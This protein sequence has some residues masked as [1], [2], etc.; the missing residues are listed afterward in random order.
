MFFFR[1]YDI[2]NMVND[3]QRSINKIIWG[4]FVILIIFFLG[5][6]I[7]TEYHKRNSLKQFNKKIFYMD[8][9]IYI[10][11][12]TKDEKTANNMLKEAEK[13]YQHY[14]QIANR[15]EEFDNIHNL[16]YIK[17]NTSKEDYITIDKDLYEMLKIGKKWYQKSNR[18]IDISLGN[19]IDVW[20][21]Y[22]NQETGVP[23][24]K[25]LKEAH[26]DSIDDI[27]LKDNN[28][29]KNNHVNIDL[30]AI[31]KGYATDKVA[32]YFKENNMN[33]Y[34]INAGGN[35]LVG[36]HYDNG[37]YKI[38]IEDPTHSNGAIYTK[39]Q[40]NN[41]AV[42]TSGGYER[43]YEYKGKKY[44]HVINPNTLFPSDDKMSVTVIGNNSTEADILSTM[45]F[46]MDIEE[47]KK[48]VDTSDNLEAIWYINEKEQIESNGFKEYY[49]E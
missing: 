20:K 48:Y 12:Y 34:L 40:A 17:N 44:H 5:Y 29:I 26:T 16:Y 41:K 1:S 3:M 7:F 47:G 25:E 9:Y 21:K 6:I 19:V 23:S 49:F 28:R 36:E 14:H 10:N 46:L 39:V 42:V 38:G 11:L 4:I 22:R 2:M 33:K 35:V 37:K 13:I 32:E 45:L 30:G 18:L 8:T 43:F 24:E 27:I 31:A 15:F